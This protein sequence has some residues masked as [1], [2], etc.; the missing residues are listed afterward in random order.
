[1]DSA[2]GAAVDNRIAEM[3]DGCDMLI[4]FIANEKM[5]VV[6]DRFFKGE[7]TDEALIHSLSSLKLGNNI[8]L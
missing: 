4:R 8:W 1:M 5:F 6:L 2:K 7:I 3:A